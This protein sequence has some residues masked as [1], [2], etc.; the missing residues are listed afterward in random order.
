VASAGKL[1]ALQVRILGTLAGLT[2]RWTLSGGGALAGVYT[3][4]RT[5]RDLDLFYQAR[6]ALEHAPEDAKARLEAV[7]LAVAVQQRAEAFCRFEV[8]DAGEMTLVD[9]VADPVPLAE[10]PVEVDLGGARIW[11][12][13]P[14]QILVNKLCALLS[15]S[16]LRDLE[17]VQALV[18][19]GL[20]LQRALADAPA[21]DGGFSPLT[22][23][24]VLRQLPIAAMAAALGSTE[25]SVRALERYRDELVEHVL[26]QAVPE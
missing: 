17:D 20:D 16:E 13:T 26:A 18:G 8:R 15:R 9:L 6:R 1:T 23:A 12:D 14:H 25:D 21:Q 19:T 2:P 22:F 24:W 11:V 4:H 3:Q 5:T 10:P 7:G